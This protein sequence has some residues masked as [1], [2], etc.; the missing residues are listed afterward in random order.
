MTGVD[1]RIGAPIVM[2]VEPVVDHAVRGLCVRPYPGHSMGCPNFGARDGCPPR[3]PMIERVFDLS[4]P[5]FL[6]AMSYDLAGHVR[7]MGERHPGW[8]DRQK[9]NLLYWQ[10]AVKARLRGAARYEACERGLVV[11]E[12]PEATGVDVTATCEQAWIILEWPPRK[13]VWK[14][15]F[16]GTPRSL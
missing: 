15:V 11:L 2:Q 6:V 12:C 9:S 8:T 10:G 3:A 5:V 14:V 1:G 7:E 13:T 4:R 16:L